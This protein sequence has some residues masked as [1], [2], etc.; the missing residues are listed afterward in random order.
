[1]SF[2]FQRFDDTKA[3]LEAV[4]RS[5]AVI[6]F[7]PDGTI[8]TANQNFLGA[9]GYS[10][11]E[12]RG[13]H[14]GMFVEP[15]YRN[16]PEYREFWQRLQRGEFQAAEFKRVAK[17]GREVWIQAS[18]NPVFDRDQKVCKVVK[19]ATDTTKQK[20]VF[21]DLNG[22][23]AA[24]DK[25]QAVIEF[26]LDGTII[27]ANENFL[28]A[29]GYTLDEIKGR[30]H[31]MFVEPSY[32]NSAEYA[33]FWR[34]LARGEYQAAQY[35]RFAKG[36]REIWIQASYN[37]I[38]DM[39]GKPF[40]VVKFAT[41][42]TAQ[43]ELLGNVRKLID[44]NVG[45]IDSAVRLA[46]T[47]ATSASGAATESSANVNS[48]ATGAEEL[49]ASIREIS[50]SMNKSLAA[51]NG[52]VSHAST[53]GVSAQKLDAASKS[54]GAIVGIIQDI[55]SQINLL[56]LN[57]TIESARAGE[58]GKG[59]AVVATEVKNLA[60]QSADA[61]AQI[62]KEI[63]DMQGVS[64]DVVGA[65]AAI[66]KSIESV[67]EYVASTAGAVEEQSAVAREMSMNMQTAANSV[68]KITG[69]ISRIAHATKDA[70][71]STKQVREAAAAFG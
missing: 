37:P 7:K 19:F 36:A 8:L 2:G 20:L 43:M 11:E 63:E 57:A 24:I 10:L 22:K 61:T 18:Y 50:E 47:E 59:F 52:T 60:K 12:I 32:K 9:M 41:D 44:E 14:H 28:G 30:H 55:A 3:T 66:R 34:S 1:M 4:S 5:Q 65:L 46:E 56:A 33:E 40:K 64:G 26:E 38:M 16:S 49:S 35:K 25:S 48:V 53:A 58:A 54:M 21:A 71:M 67:R 62:S 17:G 13:Q 31:S 6:E 69:N 23:I 42:I 39:N 15:A 45:A 68:E 51:V 70:D 27:K 29:M